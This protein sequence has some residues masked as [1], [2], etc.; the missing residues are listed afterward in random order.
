MHPDKWPEIKEKILTSF[1]VLNQEVLANQEERETIEIIE[2]VSPLGRMKLEWLKKPKVLGKKTHYTGR[3]GSAVS[4]DYV[5]SEDEYA[6]SLTVYKW[7]PAMDDW[8]E[9][10]AGNFI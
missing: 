8:Q 7:N 3:I 9:I 2:F 10:D 5:L 1:K 4:V 6:C